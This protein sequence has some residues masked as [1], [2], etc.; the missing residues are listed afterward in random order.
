[1]ALRNIR[2]LGDDVLTKKCKEVK[3]MTPRVSTLIKDMFDTM[4]EANGVGLAASQVGILKRIVVVDT[5][6]E[7]PFVMINPVIEETSGEQIGSEGCLSVPGK[8]GIV[9][10]PDYVKVS[11]LDENM[12]PVELEGTEFLA[13]AMLHEIDHLDGHMYVDK[14]EG[15][16]MTTEEFEEMNANAETAARAAEEEEK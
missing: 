13:R 7:D 9:K 2:I 14:V 12:K 1:M 16:L 8:I 15:K 3:I 5:T 4:Y 11:C 10:R 6:G